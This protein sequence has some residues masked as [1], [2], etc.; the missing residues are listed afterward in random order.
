[1]TNQEI[2]QLLQEDIKGE[3]QAIVMYLMHA[4]EVGESG[5]AC[6]IE[7]I[8]REEMRHMDWLADKITSL[9]GE[10]VMEPLPPD[11][12]PAPLSEQ[13]LKDVGLE[14]FAANQYREHIEAIEDPDIRAVLSRILHDELV[15]HGQ[16]AGFVEETK[17]IT[18]VIERV[19]TE[20]VM[21]DERTADILNQGIG[22]EYT[23]TLQYLFHGFMTGKKG[24]A[25]DWQNIAINEMQHMGWL[26]EALASRGGRPRFMRSEMVLTPDEETNLKADLAVE[27]EVT[28]TYSKQLPEIE[29]IPV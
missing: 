9:G 29:T 6:E 3:H 27:R 4:Y 18:G 23:V 2:I 20:G 13:M 5:L 8:A 11:F 10:P 16:F 25:E 22:H 24:L 1:M 12:T 28:K 15:H 14:E 17:D 19:N 26:S 7:A 21:P